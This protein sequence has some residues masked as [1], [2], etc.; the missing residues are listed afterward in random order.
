[1]AFSIK[2]TLELF[3]VRTL[4][5]EKQLDKNDLYSKINAYCKTDTDCIDSVLNKLID[6]DYLSKENNIYL[7]IPF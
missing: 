6:N 1:M 3:I 7:Y 4:K 2:E 5:R